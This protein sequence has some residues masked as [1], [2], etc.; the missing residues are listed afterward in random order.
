MSD[1]R[2]LRIRHVRRNVAE[3]ERSIAFYCDALGGV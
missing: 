3:L 2:V 1:A